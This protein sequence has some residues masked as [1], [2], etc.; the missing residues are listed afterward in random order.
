MPR[1][2]D[3][4]FTLPYQAPA[5]SNQ[6]RF[7]TTIQSI[8]VFFAV[9]ATASMGSP[10]ANLRDSLRHCI[11]RMREAARPDGPLGPTAPGGAR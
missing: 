6:L 1:G 5:Q 3:F 7:T 2:Q 8:D 4:F 10:I 9:D 11:A